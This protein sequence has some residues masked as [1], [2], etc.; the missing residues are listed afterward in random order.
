M[1]HLGIFQKSWKMSAE[2]NL[3]KKTKI[4]GALKSSNSGHI[5]FPRSITGVRP[6]PPSCPSKSRLEIYSLL[7]FLNSP[8]LPL[9]SRGLKQ[10]LRG[11]VL[12]ELN[13]GKKCEKG[14][15]CAAAIAV[16]T[17]QGIQT[18]PP[19]TIFFGRRGVRGTCTAAVLPL[20]VLLMMI[21]YEKKNKEIKT[22]KKLQTLALVS[23]LH[24]L[25]PSPGLS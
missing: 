22:G 15:V 6:Y 4:G 1:H 23:V 17:V 13:K 18:P 21:I 16:A 5:A 25:L 8:P 12:K 24:V 19:T 14:E 2:K 3:S 7:Y 11:R 9:L 20:V 10:L